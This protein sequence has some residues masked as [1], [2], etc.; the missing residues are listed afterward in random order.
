LLTAEKRSVALSAPEVYSQSSSQLVFPFVTEA[1]ST[2]NSTRISASTGALQLLD[3]DCDY[4]ASSIESNSNISALLG[5][6]DEAIVNASNELL[7]E[8]SDTLL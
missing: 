2:T 6:S 5:G 1:N 4:Q 8:L 7:V 3:I